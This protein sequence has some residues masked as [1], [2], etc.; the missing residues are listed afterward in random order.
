MDNIQWNLKQNSYIF[1]REN[2]FEN[3]VCKM[4]A[5]LSQLNPHKNIRIASPASMLGNV[6]DNW[7][8]RKIDPRGG[9]ISY[10]KPAMSFVQLNGTSPRD[11]TR[12]KFNTCHTEFI[13][14]HMDICLLFQLFLKTEKAQVA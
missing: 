8:G 14:G 7:L 9:E 11:D 4:A 1:I 2:A 5:I 10:R 13:L 3:V 12:I 6:T